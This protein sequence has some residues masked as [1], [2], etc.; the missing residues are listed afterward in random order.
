MKGLGG[1]TQYPNWIIHGWQGMWDQTFADGGSNLHEAQIQVNHLKD[2]IKPGLYDGCAVWGFVDI[3]VWSA[4]WCKG[5]S[6]AVNLF[7]LALDL[8]LERP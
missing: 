3:T 5:L 4:A 8:K 7:K 6:T 1:I 2:E